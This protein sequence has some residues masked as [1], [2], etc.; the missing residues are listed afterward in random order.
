MKLTRL[1]VT[2]FTVAMGTS[3]S[4]HADLTSPCEVASDIVESY[5]S[6]A[7]TEVKE[8]VNLSRLESARMLGP[9]ILL[10]TNN[11]VIPSPFQAATVIK[12]SKLI[13]LSQTTSEKRVKFLIERQLDGIWA[14]TA[15]DP[16]QRKAI[17][18]TISEEILQYIEET[19]LIPRQSILIEK[20]DG[21]F[22][23]PDGRWIMTTSDYRI[24]D[25]VFGIAKAYTNYEWVA[26]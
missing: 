20:Q 13:G 26:P 15:I 9:V 1:T 8:P 6:D 24:K 23:L 7:Y 3:S 5:R 2:I 14:A 22:R 16:D 21:D 17:A 11:Y 4:V 19:F 10:G 12:K 25:F 18:E